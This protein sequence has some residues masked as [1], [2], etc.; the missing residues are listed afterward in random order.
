MR[1][2]N[3]DRHQHVPAFPQADLFLVHNSLELFQI[4]AVLRTHVLQL[5]K[6]VGVEGKR[7]LA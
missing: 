1:V 5:G 2:L 4:V 6:E 7:A 3:V